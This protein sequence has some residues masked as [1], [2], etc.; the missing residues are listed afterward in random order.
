MIHSTENMKMES[1]KAPNW[2]QPKERGRRSKHMQLM[3]NH[4]NS[5]AS[6]AAALRLD[7]ELEKTKPPGPEETNI[8][9]DPTYKA[10]GCACGNN[11]QEKIAET[12]YHQED[13]A[14]PTML[15]TAVTETC[16][17][18]VSRRAHYLEM[19]ETA[20]I[21]TGVMR[22]SAKNERSV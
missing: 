20:E 15:P 22:K 6:D 9:R 19:R 18:L 5:I 7:L 1:D 14:A 11:A 2:N 4:A 8:C 16:G 10:R 17:L 13:A 12:L 21:E 3:R